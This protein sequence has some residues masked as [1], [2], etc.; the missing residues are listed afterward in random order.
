MTN[1]KNMDWSLIENLIDEMLND[2]MRTWGSYDYFII[3]EETVLVKVY[4][5]GNNR[6]MF[7]IKA[8]LIGEKLEVVEVS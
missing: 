8:Q 5:E 6:L 7:T 1:L 3:N 2:H 4:D